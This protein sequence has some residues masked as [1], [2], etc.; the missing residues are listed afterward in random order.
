LQVSDNTW[1]LD[2]AF[3]HANGS[4]II[5]LFWVYVLNK[6]SPLNCGNFLEKILPK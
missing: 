3:W 2:F 1:A 4:V 5:C 6:T